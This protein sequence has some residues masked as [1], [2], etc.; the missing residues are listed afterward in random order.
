MKPVS[1]PKKL[2][3]FFLALIMM[4]GLLDFQAAA[5]SDE[6]TLPDSSVSDAEGQTPDDENM[7][8]PAPPIILEDMK[9]F[10]ITPGVDFYKDADATADTVSQE[11]DKIIE[12]TEN[13]GFNAL[14]LNT[15]RDGEVVYKTETSTFAGVDAVELLLEKTKEKQL[16]VFAVFDL[17]RNFSSTATEENNFMSVDYVEGMLAELRSFTETYLVDAVLFSG[18]ETEQN[19][20]NYAEYMRSGGGSGYAAFLRGTTSYYVKNAAAVVR[21]VRSSVPAG[22]LCG[23]VWAN[24]EETEGGSETKAVHQSYAGGYADTRSMVLN[25]RLDFFMVNMPVSTLDAN[26]PFET[27]VN[28]WGSLANEAKTPMYILHDGS[29]VCSGEPG[30]AGHDQLIRQMS[31]SKKAGDYYK[32]SAFSGMERI[33]SNPNGSTDAL[34]LYISDQYSD[35]DLFKDLTMKSPS[36]FVF[37]TY[38]DKVVFSGQYDPVF[39]VSI[40]GETIEPTVAGEFYLHYPLAIGSNRFVVSSKGGSVTYQITRKVQILQE[41][42]PT[43]TLVIDGGNIIS[44]RAVAYKGSSV[45]A[46]LGGATIALQEGVGDEA[47]ADSAYTVF[48]A[49]YTLPA[50]NTAGPVALGSITFSGSFMG[51]YETRKG[52]SVTIKKVEPVR[53]GNPDAQARI[54]AAYADVFE[55]GGSYA[56]P[57]WFNLPKDT[58]DYVDSE[59]GNY[60]ILNSGRKVRK[61]DVQLFSGASN[62]ANSLSKL[63]L[64]SDGSSTYLRVTQNWKAPFNI[65]FEPLN[66]SYTQNNTSNRFQASTVVLTFDYAEDAAAVTGSSPMF[67]GASIQKVVENGIPRVKVKLNLA[68]TGK[69]Y[70]AYAY[71]DGN[72]LVLE[73]N[74]VSTSLSGVRVFIDIGHGGSDPGAVKQF[75]SVIYREADITKGIADKLAAKLRAAGATVQFTTEEQRAAYLASTNIYGRVNAA[76]SFKADIF[77]S[78]HINA[79]GGGTATGFEAFYNDPFSQPLAKSIADSLSAS[80]GDRNRGGKWSEFAVTRDK[81]FASTLIE[82]NFIDTQSVAQKLVTDSYQNQLAD[83][84]VQGIRNYLS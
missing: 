19:G 37:S 42:K 3:A 17:Y 36:Q 41:V 65:S 14:I 78:V 77:L 20:A 62:G 82:Y 7:A 75:G 43:E 40:N 48:G 54:T 24:G 31:L 2:T 71:Y 21:E 33:V 55:Q 53:P 58:I 50:G 49:E 63:A 66:F 23:P 45:T 4:F 76:R 26:I 8:E 47:V 51:F 5:E 64:S 46:T 60:Y 79:G 29:K 25:A 9:A 69:Y 32:G 27:T 73:F 83:A 15:V 74:Q 11:L 6:S 39:D 1:Y 67:S 35:S 13:L 10:V 44:L 28:W 16:Y 34:L 70:G 52:S 30:W 61:S 59:A 57:S 80:T 72:D 38:E 18:F 68:R 12:D 56:S 84:T 22:L 81:Q